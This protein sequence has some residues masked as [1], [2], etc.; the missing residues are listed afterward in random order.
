MGS[1]V[2]NPAWTT[3]VQRLA[4]PDAG[5]GWAA[6]VERRGPLPRGTVEPGSCSDEVLGLL[7]SRA[8]TPQ[9]FAA[10]SLA[11]DRPVRSIAWS[12]VFLRKA[13][14]IRSKAVEGGRCLWWAPVAA[15]DAVEAYEAPQASVAS[16]A[17]DLE[18]DQP[19]IEPDI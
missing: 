12:L 8:G 1:Q 16:G 15:D 4:T 6:P 14:H 13:G 2:T 18:L 10:I 17:P 7:R 19:V 3:V 11:V 9:T 5:R